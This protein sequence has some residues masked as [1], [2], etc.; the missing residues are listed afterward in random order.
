MIRRIVSVVVL[1]L[2][3][4]SFTF[5]NTAQ[6]G[7]RAAGGTGSFTLLF[8][9]DSLSYKKVQMRKELV[10]I[11]LYKGFAVVKGE[12]WM[13]NDTEEVISMKTGY[14]ISAQYTSSKNNASDLTEIFFDKLFKLK[15]IVDNQPVNYQKL[16]FETSDPKIYPVV[17][18]EKP[19]WYIWT[20]NFN[21]GETK[22]EVYFII[23][24]NDSKVSRGYSK[25]S[26]NGFIYV[27]ETGA[28]W[29]PPIGAGKIR[30]QLMEGLT[31]KDIKGVSP[32]SIFNDHEAENFLEYSF[33]NL[34]PDHEDNVVI[35]YSKRVENFNFE[36]ITSQSSVYFKEVDS[37]SMIT[38]DNSTNNLVDF[39]SPFDISNSGNI[40]VNLVM[41]FIVYGMPIIVGL[42][43]ILIIA[44]IIKR[45]KR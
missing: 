43:I 32:G 14:P 36:N 22:I 10:S 5:A 38:T 23:N 25:E 31:K 19:K 44:R 30:V 28:S 20:T 18:N 15:V 9:E 3:A 33:E 17:Y 35:T 39:D 37:F 21:P 12:Y 29:K 42:I 26:S 13:Y 4:V 27:L 41:Y 11:Q 40:A 6:P 7:I 24:T 8:P 1:T 34:V 2:I 45:R 16:E